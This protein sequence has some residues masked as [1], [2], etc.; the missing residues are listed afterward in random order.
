MQEQCIFYIFV[1]TVVLPRDKIP[2]QLN[3]TVFY[4]QPPTT[5]TFRTPPIT[6][7]QLKN[8]KSNLTFATQSLVRY[9]APTST[10]TTNSH[11]SNTK[12][13]MVSNKTRLKTS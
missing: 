11:K 6:T 10:T 13:K 4:S 12:Q 2:E 3:N 1:N 7:H 5:Y 9:I 8:Y